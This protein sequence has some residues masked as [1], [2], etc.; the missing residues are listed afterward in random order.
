MAKFDISKLAG[1]KWIGYAAA[2]VAAIVAFAGSIQDQQKEKT[3]KDLAE[4]V[5]QLENK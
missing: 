3:I 4:R 2:G 1:A 5:S